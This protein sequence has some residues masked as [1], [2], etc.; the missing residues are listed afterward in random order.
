MNMDI[1]RKMRMGPRPSRRGS[2][3][4]AVL[5]VAMILGIIGLASMQI[6]RIEL[7]AGVASD[8]MARAA[9]TAQSAVEFALGRVETDPNWRTTY[10]HGVEEPA[11]SWI[12]LDATG[13]FKFVFLDS[14]GDLADDPNDGV[15]VR[16][17]GRAGGATS[18]ATVQLEPAGSG[19][20]SLKV[21]LHAAG[22]VDFN[23][24]TFNN[25]QILSSNNNVHKYS[26]VVNSDVEAVNNIT[27][28]INGFTTTGV[29]PRDMPDVST[30]FDYYLANGT[31]IDLNDI[32]GAKIEKDLLSAA[33]NPYGPGTTNPQGIYVIDCLG[34]DI[35][36]V[37][38][39]LEAT[40]VLLNAGSGSKIDNDI[41]WEPAIANFPTLMVQGDLEMQWHGEHQLSESKAGV[42]FNPPGTPYQGVTDTDTS[43]NYQGVI[44]G[45]IYVTGNLTITH[46][47]VLEGTVVVGG[48]TDIQKDVSL[49]YR[50]TFFNNPPPGFRAGSA[51]S[52][53]PGTWKRDAY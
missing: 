41:H 13:D 7:R 42:N 39:R 5:G 38:A 8:E 31:W 1:S 3:Y 51:M 18:V 52:L 53:V 9:L 44:K 34:N 47:C 19:L 40:L 11:N 10:T 48:M 36:I 49:T 6:A 4:V 28:S 32:P 27:G 43:D 25:D 23:G 35:T 14:D 12:S 45:L 37:D 2:V 20:T 26:G 50:A 46:Q 21:A 22:N 30:V 33:N 16:G 15:T 29:A 17:I 24:G